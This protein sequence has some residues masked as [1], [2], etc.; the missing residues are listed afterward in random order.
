M[1]GPP[2]RDTARTPGA[3]LAL[4]RSTIRPSSKA[5]STSSYPKSASTRPRKKSGRALPHSFVE[6]LHIV[7]VTVEIRVRE[8]FVEVLEIDCHRITEA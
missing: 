8:M 7:Q 6:R 3:K 2:Y 4:R 1:A 5:P